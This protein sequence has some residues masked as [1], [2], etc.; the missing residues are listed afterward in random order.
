MSDGTM[1]AASRGARDAG[2]RTIG[3]TVNVFGTRMPNEFLD[4]EIGTASLLMRMDK[5]A[6]V[7]NAFVVLTGGIG[8]FLELALVWNLRVLRV[9]HE[10]PIVVVGRPWRAAIEAIAQHLLIR[11]VDLAAFIFVDSPAEAV[12][13]VREALAARQP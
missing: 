4:E 13:A 3:V 5:L 11:E 1:E 2:G 12:A 10:K 6:E 7:G 9:Y 8:T